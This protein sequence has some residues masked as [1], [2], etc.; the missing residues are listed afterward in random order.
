MIVLYTL[1][2]TETGSGV[3]IQRTVPGSQ[4]TITVSSLLPFTAYFCSIAASSSVGIG[5]FSTILSVTTPEDSKRT[6]NP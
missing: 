4:T 2:V 5:P 1:N 3:T 6:I